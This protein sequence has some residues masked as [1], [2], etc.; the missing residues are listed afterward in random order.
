MWCSSMLARTTLAA[1]LAATSVGY[2]NAQQFQAIFSGLNEVPPVISQGQGTL[3]LTLNA[4]SL[5]YTLL[6]TNLSATAAAAHIQF[7]KARDNGG[8]NRIFVWRCSHES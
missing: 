8:V 1:A 6:F 3:T 5:S 4:V 7:A 2:A